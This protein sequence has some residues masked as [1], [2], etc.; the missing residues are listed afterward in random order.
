MDIIEVAG[1]LNA[2]VAEAAEG[3]E[4]LRVAV[5]A[6]E[7]SGRLG[8]KIDEDGEGLWKGGGSGE[9]LHGIYGSEWLRVRMAKIE[10]SPG[11]E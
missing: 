4:G 8:A 11:L 2:V 1:R 10:Y 7:P 9:L 3:A 5:L 6:H